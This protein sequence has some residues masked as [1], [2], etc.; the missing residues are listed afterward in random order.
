MGQGSC[1]G[2]G[3]EVAVGGVR[4]VRSPG[5]E[6]LIKRLSLQ[7]DPRWAGGGR[8]SWPPVGALLGS[9]LSPPSTGA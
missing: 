4:L 3:Q 8:Y 7:R 9:R 1:A 6:V 5:A 2:C